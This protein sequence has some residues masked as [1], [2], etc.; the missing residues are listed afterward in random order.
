MDGNGP[1]VRRATSEAPHAEGAVAEIL[2]GIG[3]APVALLLLFC[4]PS[5]DLAGVAAG[6]SRGLA[7]ATVAGCTT[8]GEITPRGYRTGTV[9]AVAFSADRFTATARLIE[10]MSRFR[11]EDGQALV[12]AMREEHAAARGDR[13]GR[14][15][16]LLISD[17]LSMSEEILVSILG[18]AF[19]EIP[20]IGGSAG[21]D[22]MFRETHVLL[23][24]ETRKDAAIVCLV[25]TDLPFQTFQ[26]QHFVSS[27]EKLVVTRADPARRLVT[28]I[29]AEPAAAEYARL[30]GLRDGELTPAV[31]AAHPLVVR[32]AGRDYVRSIQRVHD[33][34]SLSFFCAID[35]GIVMTVAASV[36]LIANL[37]DTFDDLKRGVGPIEAVLGFDCVFR[38]L[39]MEQRQILAPVQN[40][41]VENRVTGF[42]TYGEQFGMMHVNQ[43]FTGI[44]F[45]TGGGTGNGHG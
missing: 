33:D 13:K 36:D 7:G 19:A 25:T 32:A 3:P 22:L 40:L 42:S 30:I 4:S 41:M 18:D 10:P 12:H 9:T 35:E 15:F 43:T 23:G 27:S 2:A 8:A 45:G 5:Y 29:N 14:T 38:Y 37:A 26:T 11:F 1:G 39:E 21:D 44:A 6:L 28:E 20:L 17:G 34:G 16:A 24:G 31:F